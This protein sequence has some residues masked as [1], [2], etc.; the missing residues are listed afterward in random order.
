MII[1]LVRDK[2]EAFTDWVESFAVVA[3]ARVGGAETGACVV[4]VTTAADTL[5]AGVV[6]LEKTF[7]SMD[8]AASVTFMNCVVSICEKGL[9]PPATELTAAVRVLFTEDMSFAVLFAVFAAVNMN[10]ISYST[11]TPVGLTSLRD[12]E[13]TEASAS[14]R[15]LENVSV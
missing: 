15:L 11:L 6:T 2:P 9:A 12:T 3:G 8:P 1:L 4:A 14:A 5:G 13:D 10:R 7:A